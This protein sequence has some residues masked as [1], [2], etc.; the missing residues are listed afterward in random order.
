MLET[1]EID[2]ETLHIKAFFVFHESL[3]VPEWSSPYLQNVLGALAVL[4]VDLNL[5]V[6][7]GE[8]G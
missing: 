5:V 8:T 3:E 6:S 4:A 7:P 1:S 2:S